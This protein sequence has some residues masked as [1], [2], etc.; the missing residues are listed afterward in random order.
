MSDYRNPDDPLRRDLGHDPKARSMNATW[1]WIAA[2][3]FIVVVL[4]VAFG[5]G[6]RPGSG[7][8]NVAS[9]STTPPA[10][11]QMPPPTMAP[12]PPPAATPTPSSTAPAPISPAPN[13]P[14]QSSQ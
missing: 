10:V 1:G 13:S 12:A 9:N 5:T 11:T 2:A 6:Y 3:V 14:A 7:Y 4:A 8:S